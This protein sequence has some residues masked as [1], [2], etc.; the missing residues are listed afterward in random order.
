MS[1]LVTISV[2]LKYH[3]LW[4]PWDPLESLRPLTLT[5]ASVEGTW[6]LFDGVPFGMSSVV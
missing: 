1:G 6:L 3:I 2:T 5:L 4:G